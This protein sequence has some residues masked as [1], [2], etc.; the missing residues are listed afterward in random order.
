MLDMDV[1][2]GIDKYRY[3]LDIM[4][5]CKKYTLYTDIKQRCYKYMYAIKS[6]N[7]YNTYI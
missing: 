3:D 1:R 5:N 6:T 2:H 7:I 4:D